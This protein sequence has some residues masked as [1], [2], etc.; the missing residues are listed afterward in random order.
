[1]NYSQF[2][3]KVLLPLSIF[4]ILLN[5]EPSKATDWTEDNSLVSCQSN[6]TDMSDAAE[7]SDHNKPFSY[8][9]TYTPPH[10]GC[11][12][13]P[14]GYE[15][16]IYKL[17][18]CTSDPFDSTDA[19]INFS[20]SSCV[21]TME[22]EG[23][24]KIDLAANLNTGI[25]LPSA[26]T[27]PPNGTYTHFALVMG[28][29][30]RIKGSYTTTDATNGGTFYTK[31]S[32]DPSTTNSSGLFDKS[33]SSAEFFTEDFN[34]GSGFKVT[35]SCDFN[36]QR[37]VTGTNAGLVRAVVANSALA[38]S[39]DCTSVSRIVGVYKPNT[40]LEITDR[41]N[42]LEIQFVVTGSGLFVEGGGPGDS[43]YQPNWA[44]SGDFVPTF[45]TF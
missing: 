16:T 17:G 42:G 45:K 1:M 39:T 34:N 2:S 4:G 20:D 41:T 36:Y 7:G 44:Y 11:Y 10:V 30:I 9:S 38:T 23:G 26:N 27:R 21:W 13:T 28:E 6:Q 14:E 40:S 22:S 35:G 25:S 31:P 24:S 29:N 8:S 43:T 18:M 32:P 19:D 15:I 12:T 37:T 5:F 33:L 3:K